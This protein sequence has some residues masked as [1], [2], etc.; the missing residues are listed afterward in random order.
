MGT[1][2]CRSA[3]RTKSAVAVEIKR[4]PLEEARNI[5]QTIPAPRKH[6]Q[7]VIQ[8]FYEATGLMVDKIVRNQVEPVV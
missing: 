6:F 1:T 4:Q 8:P 5:P 3:P 7:L 2:I